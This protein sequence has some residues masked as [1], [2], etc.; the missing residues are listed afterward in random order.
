MNYFQAIRV[1]R[2]AAAFQMKDKTDYS[3]VVWDEPSNREYDAEGKPITGTEIRIPSEAECLAIETQ[4]NEAVAAEEKDI[5]ARTELERR[6]RKATRLLVKFAA[7]LPS[8]PPALKAI[9]SE[10]AQFE[11][12][13]RGDD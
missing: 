1:L 8:A 7:S 5:V 13:L 11:A 4:V 9:A 10:I 2:P 6:Y 12:D 3:T